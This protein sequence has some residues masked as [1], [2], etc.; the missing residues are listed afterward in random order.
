MKDVKP[1]TDLER[2]A[3][4]INS[5][6]VVRCEVKGNVLTIKKNVHNCTPYYVVDEKFDF[7]EI[8]KKIIDDKNREKSDKS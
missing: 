6:L 8:S 4:V 5:R 7:N 2:L 1:F 3:E